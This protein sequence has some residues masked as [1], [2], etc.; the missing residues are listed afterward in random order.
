[1]FKYYAW[2]GLG[3]IEKRDIDRE[4]EKYVIFKNGRKA[5]K[6]TDGEGYFDTFKEAQEFVFSMINKELDHLNNRKLELMKRW[7]KIA[8][9]DEDTCQKKE[10]LTGRT[11]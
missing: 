7:E 3:S 5:M 8:A 9:L 1:M 11:A 6:L 10:H 4:T 2:S